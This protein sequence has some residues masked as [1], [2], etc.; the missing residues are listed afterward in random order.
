[1]DEFRALY[2]KSTAHSNHGN[3]SAST[4]SS[5]SSSSA[6]RS[7][8][9]DSS[10]ITPFNAAA[11][12]AN[13]GKNAKSSL[14]QLA[15]APWDCEYCNTRNAPSSSVLRRCTSCLKKH[16]GVR[17]VPKFATPSN[18]TSRRP[19]L[20]RPAEPLTKFGNGSKVRT[21]YTWYNIL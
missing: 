2:E 21:Q 16:T 1:M 19:H 20:L 9:T 7:A 5:T 18:S 15:D 10:S 8:A 14:R 11:A 13:P 4:S 12:S 3:S 6:S 17:S